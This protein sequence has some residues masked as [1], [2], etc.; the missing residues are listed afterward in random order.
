MGQTFHVRCIG[1]ARR[2]Q[3]RHH[4][5]FD[6]DKERLGRVGHAGRDG[7]LLYQQLFVEARGQ[8][9][10]QARPGLPIVGTPEPADGAVLV[11][12]HGIDRFTAELLRPVRRLK[13]APDPKFYSQRLARV[14]RVVVAHQRE[15]LVDNVVV[16][17]RGLRRRL[18][19]LPTGD[20]H[21]PAE[22][23]R[24]GIERFERIDGITPAANEAIGSHGHETAERRLDVVGVRRR[25]RQH[26]QHR[27]GQHPSEICRHARPPC[28]NPMKIRHPA[29]GSNRIAARS[30]TNRTTAL[31]RCQMK[32]VPSG[33]A[34]Q[35]A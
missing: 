16:A 13:A 20:H 8:L 18:Q 21:K 23:T 29:F 19:L 3:C 32:C 9:L 6:W 12:V 22:D 33:K 28:D 34:R 4:G 7:D 35:T 1:E 24:L 31:S 10:L 30:S 25:Y 2:A 27:A 11:S 5:I 14:S 26:A 15:R 17:D